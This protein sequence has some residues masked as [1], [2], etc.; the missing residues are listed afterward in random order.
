MTP[1]QYGASPCYAELTAVTLA[2]LAHILLEISVSEAV[3]RWFSTGVALAFVTYLVWR[4]RGG[5]V[6]L[7]AW[8]MRRDN[9]W[10]ALRAQSV[11]GVGGATVMLVY[12]AT[13]GS[14]T[15]PWLADPGPLSDLGCCTVAPN[16]QDRLAWRSPGFI[17]PSCLSHGEDRAD[18]S[19]L[20]QCF[21]ND[22]LEWRIQLNSPSPE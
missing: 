2:G 13:Q 5:M 14:I 18:V 7:H 12:A 22:N 19:F 11:F 1:H 8:G 9:F 17:I 15:V 20:P 6:V 4:A 21:I 16:E 10:R 3:A